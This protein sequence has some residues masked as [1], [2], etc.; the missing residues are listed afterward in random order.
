LLLSLKNFLIFFLFF[1]RKYRVKNLFLI[2]KIFSKKKALEIGGPSRFFYKNVPLYQIMN[3]VDGANFSDSTPRDGLIKKGYDY[4]GYYKNKKGYNYICDATNLNEIGNKIYDCVISS[5]CL[6]HV[7]NPIKALVEWKRV[8]KNDGYIFL[9]LPNAN[10]TLD[11]RR[12]ITKFNHL[13]DDYNSNIQ[14]DDKT[15]V[16]DVIRNE[17][18]IIDSVTKNKKHFIRMA[19]D[20]LKYRII[21]HH[22]FDHLLIK[23]ICEHLNLKLIFYGNIKKDD[24]YLIKLK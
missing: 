12:K 6:E 17:A 24:Y 7:A 13:L 16:E 11:K 4:Y 2:I 8:I 3:L 19:N 20:N 18:F 15:H 9:V 22:V 23:K 5:N 21:H 14:E 10:L 1:F